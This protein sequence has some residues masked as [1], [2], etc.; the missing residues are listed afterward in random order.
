ML[1]GWPAVAADMPARKP[2]LWEIKMNFERV[3]G[4]NHPAVHRCRD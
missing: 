2:G 4:Q 3:P 1:A